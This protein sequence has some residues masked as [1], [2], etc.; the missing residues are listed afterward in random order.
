MN[1]AT[2]CDKLA[3][4]RC[5]AFGATCMFFAGDDIGI[6]VYEYK[7]DALDTHQL[8]NEL[9]HLGYAPRVMSDVFSFDVKAL[10]LTYHAYVTEKAEALVFDVYKGTC[11]TKH[12]PEMYDLLCSM[13]QDGYIDDDI[14]SEN[15]AWMPDGR[16][17]VIDVN[18]IERRKP[19]EYNHSYCW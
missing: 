4:D 2:V 15:Y 18:A 16:P 5:D 10:N 6:K 3:R 14:H 17:V 13:F 1:V 11:F 8:Q 19:M 7:C 9:Y 12:Y